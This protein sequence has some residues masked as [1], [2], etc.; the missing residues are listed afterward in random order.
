MKKRLIWQV[1]FVV[2][3]FSSLL[4]LSPASSPGPNITLEG[5]YHCHQGPGIPLDKLCD[6]STDCPLGDDEGDLCREYTMTQEHSRSLEC[7]RAKLMGQKSFLHLFFNQNSIVVK[8][9]SRCES[10]LMKPSHPAHQSNN[11]ASACTLLTEMQEE[12][13]KKR[14]CSYAWLAFLTL[15]I[16]CGCYFY[17][18]AHLFSAF[19]DAWEKHW[20]SMLTSYS[21]VKS[22]RPCCLRVLVCQCMCAFV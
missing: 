2:F 10:S 12:R 18:F 7:A 5:Q 20:P 11:W 19:P 21:Q 4:L 13:Q 8:L 1:L 17:L 14:E 15:D 22:P 16:F 6:F 3:P 9:V